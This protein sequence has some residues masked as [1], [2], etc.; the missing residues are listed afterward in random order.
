MVMRTKIENIRA[1]YQHGYIT[2]DEAK[3]QVMPLLDTMNASGRKIA[4]EFGR[5]FK[6]LTFSYVFR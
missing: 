2:L 3:E 4:K 1:Q 6:P 5:T